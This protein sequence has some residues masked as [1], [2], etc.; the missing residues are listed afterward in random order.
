MIKQMTDAEIRDLIRQQFKAEFGDQFLE[1]PT[2]QRLIKTLE[3]IS[4]ENRE[5]FKE[6]VE[7]YLL[8]TD[9]EKYSE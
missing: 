1:E 6:F 7:Q 4:I 2:M 8:N 5:Q 9:W 3:D